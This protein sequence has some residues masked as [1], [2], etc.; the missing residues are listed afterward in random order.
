MSGTSVAR[1]ASCGK[2]AEMNENTRKIT[3]NGN[4]T[5]NIE[6]A[7]ATP[8]EQSI[9]QIVNHDEDVLVDNKTT[10]RELLEVLRGCPEAI[11]AEKIEQECKEEDARLVRLKENLGED[12]EGDGEAD[13][14]IFKKEK[15][16]P[17]AV[18]L[19]DNYHRVAAFTGGDSGKLEVYANGYAVYDNGDRRTVVWVP[20]CGS[21]TYYFGPLRDNEREYLKQKSDI[22]EDV[23]GPE[24][25]YV[26]LTIAGED[27]IE[28][29]LIHP[30]TK[31]SA[32]A[33]GTED[34]DIKPDYRWRC[35]GHIETPE[36]ALIRKENERERREALTERQKEVYDMYMQG[37]NQYQIGEKLGIAQ[38]AVHYHI[39]GIKKKLKKNPEIFFTKY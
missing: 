28:R 13:T 22:G 31:A 26:A 23:L 2:D 7:E 18:Q 16:R 8:D 33:L 24:P 10:F 3:I 30:K 35:G 12:Y 11:D 21:T 37:L 29:N 25:W 6:R 17:G 39:E 34:E 38:N 15:R 20:D 36:E 1:S 4:A 32:S 5:I 9:G 14:D 19:W 27:S